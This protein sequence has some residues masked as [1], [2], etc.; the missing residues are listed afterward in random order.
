MPFLEYCMHA[1]SCPTLCNPM[2]CSLPRPPIHKISQ[3]RILECVAIS[4]ARGS[5]QSRDRTLI[6]CTGRQVLYQW[7]TWE[8]PF[9][10]LVSL[11]LFNLSFC[12]SPLLYLHLHFLFS[13]SNQW[14][15]LCSSILSLSISNNTITHTHTHTYPYIYII[16]SRIT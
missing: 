14:Q 3:A 1:Q 5:S 11:L 16:K 15:T 12:H 13:K 10:A 4:F 8:A 6:S 7:A 2:N 9:I